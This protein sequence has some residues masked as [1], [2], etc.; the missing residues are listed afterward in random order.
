MQYLMLVFLLLAGCSFN[1]EKTE[2]PK[3]VYVSVPLRLPAKPQFPK[4]QAE[5]L[6]CL[7]DQAKSELLYRDT[8]IKSYIQDLE[9]VITSTQKTK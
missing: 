2:P 9:T 4:I 6:E 8:V 1:V 5:S 3:T 7:D